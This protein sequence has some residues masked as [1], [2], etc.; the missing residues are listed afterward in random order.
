MPNNIKNA[1]GNKIKRET[2][3]M[4][5]YKFIDIVK[6]YENLGIHMQ[7]AHGC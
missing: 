2:V 4:N 1:L 7:L 5:I 6:S 3:H